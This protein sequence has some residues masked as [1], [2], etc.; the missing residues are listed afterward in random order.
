[1]ELD[2][3]GLG[4]KRVNIGQPA[5]NNQNLGIAEIIIIPRP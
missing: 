1:M 3:Q 4:N 5:A 2:L